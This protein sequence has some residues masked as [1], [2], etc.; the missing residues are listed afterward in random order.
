VSEQTRAN[1]LAALDGLEAAAR[2]RYDQ[3]KAAL[4]DCTPVPDAREA[5]QMVADHE[6]YY[7]RSLDECRAKTR[8]YTWVPGLTAATIAASMRA[9]FGGRLLAELDAM[10]IEIRRVAGVFSRDIDT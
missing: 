9:D 8:V 3:M 4:R 1:V 2:S 7:L 5:L 10:L 6:A